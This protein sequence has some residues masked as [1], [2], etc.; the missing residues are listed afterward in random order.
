M[1]AIKS[2][3]QTV[4]TLK[5]QLTVFEQNLGMSRL[6]LASIASDDLQCRVSKLQALMACF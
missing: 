6:R 2:L 3:R 1:A 4:C 5:Q